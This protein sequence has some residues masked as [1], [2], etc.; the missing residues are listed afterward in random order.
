MLK[1]EKII[2]WSF[3]LLIFTSFSPWFFWFAP[4]ILNLLIALLLFLLIF[5]FKNIKTNRFFIFI[6]LYVVGISV[7]LSL[8]FNPI[9]AISLPLSSSL[10]ALLDREQLLSISELFKKV[11]A[12]VLLPGL[13]LWV[14]HVF[15]GDLNIGR[16]GSLPPNLISEIKADYGV[17]YALYPFS[18]RIETVA[19]DLY[20]SGMYRF[21]SV[22]DEPGFLGTICALYLASQGINKFDKYS[23]IILLAGLA[24]FSL[25]FYFIYFLFFLMV[26]V[27]NIKTFF[28]IL[29]I[30]FLALTPIFLHTDIID[31][32]I[33]S[34]IHISDAGIVGDNRT[35]SYTDQAFVAWLNT[36]SLREFMLGVD[37]QSDGSSSW[38]L[39][40]ING[41]FLA[42]ISLLSFYLILAMNFFGKN[43]ISFQ[44]LAF[45]IVFVMSAYQRVPYIGVVYLFVFVNAILHSK[46]SGFVSGQ[47][48]KYT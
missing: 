26:G 16:L 37:Y 28:Y 4:G 32:F 42:A 2:S 5:S 35:G 41:G 31:S 20:F 18:I 21:Q 13:L 38:K 45:L 25:A 30:F 46:T 6:T 11:L 27:K 3:V 48:Y 22:F 12:I 34:R 10:I 17:T 39:L 23:L 33:L 14:L 36:T 7:L 40:F 24:S 15:S 44:F 1:S 8:G 29:S 9:L 19:L 43:K 47:H